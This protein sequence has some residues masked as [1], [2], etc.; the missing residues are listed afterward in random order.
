MGGPGAG[1]GTQCRKLLAK[2]PHLDS[3]SV[4]DLLR[5]KVKEGTEEGKAL[6][7]KM[8]RGELISSDYVAGLM[9][10]YMGRKCGTKV[11]LA[12]GFPRSKENMTAWDWNLG[13]HIS[14]EFLL[15]FELKDESMLSRLRGRAEATPPDKR[16]ADDNEETYKKRIATFHEHEESF[17]RFKDVG[18]ELGGKKYVGIDADRDVEEI[19]KEVI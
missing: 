13:D 3:F 2:Y 5:A 1:K 9:K 16:R 11:F 12:D 4:G 8:K 10:T 17:S 19:H 14:T 15:L 18:E 7:E 6:G